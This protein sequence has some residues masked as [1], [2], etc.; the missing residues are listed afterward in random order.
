[1]ISTKKDED[2]IIKW[3]FG[4]IIYNKHNGK[5]ISDRNQWKWATNTRFQKIMFNVAEI[6]NIPI[7]RSWYMWGGYIHTP[8][9]EKTGFI[10]YRKIYSNK[11]E[12]V[13]K[14][15]IQ[16]KNLG[17]D[18]DAIINEIIKQTIY[19][20]STSMKQILPIYYKEKPP[21]E[22]VSLYI[23]KQNLNDL[24]EIFSTNND[25]KEKKHFYKL[26][27]NYQ[28]NYY[29]YDEESKALLDEKNITS[30]KNRFYTLANATLDKIETYVLKDKIIE[31][32]IL[33]FFNDISNYYKE[34]IW[35]PYA[36]IVS[37]NTLKGFRVK[38]EKR[39]MAE[40]EYNS[41]QYG[42]TK[43]DELSHRLKIKNIEPSL[44]EYKLLNSALTLQKEVTDLINE[45]LIIYQ[46][47]VDED[48]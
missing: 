37:Q 22:Y 20:T 4:E 43:L 8:L 31:H 34:Y 25:Y 27:K 9:S 19:F 1:M 24:F 21:T 15:R 10:V 33:S 32:H 45:L 42:V 12:F 36:S 11:P 38:E 5:R 35:Q 23:S 18:T 26:E 40:K 47:K 7:T 46:K 6:F 16:V 2:I 29:I 13:E 39:A 14:L 48:E 28:K 3:I 44:Q 17:F 41:I 30:T